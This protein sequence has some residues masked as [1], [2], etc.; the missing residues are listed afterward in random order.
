MKA[1]WCSVRL[2][3]ILIRH[4]KRKSIARLRSG[5]AQVERSLHP[6]AP[7]NESSGCRDIRTRKILQFILAVGQER[8]PKALEGAVMRKGLEHLGQNLW[9]Q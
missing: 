6:E 3:K 1:F 2:G 5:A 7:E 4:D 8:F 9:R